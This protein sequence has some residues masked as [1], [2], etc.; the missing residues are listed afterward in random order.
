MNFHRKFKLINGIIRGMMTEKATNY[1]TSVFTKPVSQLIEERF[2]CRTY[3]PQ[4]VDHDTCEKLEGYVDSLPEGPFGSRMRFKLVSAKEN[5]GDEL[6]RLGTYGFIRGATGYVI[7]AVGDQ[8]YHL[9]DCG[10]LPRLSI[11]S[12]RLLRAMG[13]HGKGFLPMVLG[14]GCVTMSTMTTRILSSKKE[15]F[16]ATLLLALGIPCSAQ[17]GVILAITSGISAQALAVVFV[18]VLLQLV[19]VGHALARIYPGR[20]SSFVLELPPIRWPVWTN[21]AKSNL[22]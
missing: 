17:L 22:G 7:G 6:K 20:R 5:D 12:D 2:S 8:P 16:I 21:I 9:E 13:L 4:P 3:L 10:Y 1:E 14:L 15:R 11:L 19:I 18:T